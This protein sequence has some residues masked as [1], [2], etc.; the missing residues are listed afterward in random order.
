MLRKGSRR[1]RLQP[2]RGSA[3]VDKGAADQV[4]KLLSAT[5]VKRLAR[6]GCETFLLSVSRLDAG[7]QQEAQ[8]VS[9]GTGTSGGLQPVRDWIQDNIDVFPDQLPDGLPPERGTGHAIP[10][11]PGSKPV[12]GPVYRASPAEKREIE[13]HVKE[14]VGKGFMEQSDS[15]HASPVIFVVKKDGTLRMCVD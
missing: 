7:E 3:P 6:Q 11:E 4:P 2:V 12:F 1:V 10:L 15:P 13:R 14:Y 9:G 8:P 5:Q